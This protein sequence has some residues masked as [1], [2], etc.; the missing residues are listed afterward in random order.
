MAPA[1]GHGPDE[2]AA[3]RSLGG[4]PPGPSPGPSPPRSVGRLAGG[5]CRGPGPAQTQ[6]LE[7]L[8]RRLRL[9]PLP[10]PWESG[11]LIGSAPPGPSSHVRRWTAGLQET[12]M[13]DF[14]FEKVESALLRKDHP[15]LAPGDTVKVHVKVK[16]G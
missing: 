15:K 16:E 1:R 14:I 9:L 8:A 10:L 7:G 12:H 4:L 13:S 2:A 6:G 3:A 5:A 11:R